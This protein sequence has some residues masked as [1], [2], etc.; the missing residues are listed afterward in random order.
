MNF[1]GAVKRTMPPE[2]VV[3][4][5]LEAYNARDIDGLIAI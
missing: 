5:Q 3:Q 4:R 1:G 2:S